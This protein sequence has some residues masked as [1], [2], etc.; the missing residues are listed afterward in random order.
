MLLHF[1]EMDLKKSL[2][3]ER[4]EGREEGRVEERDLLATS[5]ERIR[6]GATGEELLSEGIDEKTVEFALKYA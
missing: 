1:D 6:A 3:E 5:I 2:E 4:E